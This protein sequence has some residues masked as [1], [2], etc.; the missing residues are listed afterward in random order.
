MRARGLERKELLSGIAADLDALN[1]SFHGLKERVE[2]LVPCNCSP[3]RTRPMP[4][5]FEQKR[6]LQRKRDGKLKV[7]CPSSY[8]D[9]FLPSQSKY[10]FQGIINLMERFAIK[11]TPDMSQAGAMVNRTGFPCFRTLNGFKIDIHHHAAIKGCHD[12]Q[13]VMADSVRAFNSES[14]S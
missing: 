7:E 13:S 6:L 2:K 9:F 4:E 10:D 12:G 5:S 14:S 1:D 3:C 8:E 11:F